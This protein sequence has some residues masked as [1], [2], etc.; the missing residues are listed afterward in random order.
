MSSEVVRIKRIISRSGGN[1]R[2]PW[3]ISSS[4]PCYKHFALCLEN[5]PCHSFHFVEG[6]E[7]SRGGESHSTV[8][9]QHK[10]ATKSRYRSPSLF[11]ICTDTQDPLT[12][13]SVFEMICA[14]HLKVYLDLRL[15]QFTLLVVIVCLTLEMQR[16]ALSNVFTQATV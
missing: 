15:L 16:G 4:H 9:Q 14:Q 5:K 11:H 13:F 2:R 8:I 6:E 10:Y 3:P 7:Y 12:V 1:L